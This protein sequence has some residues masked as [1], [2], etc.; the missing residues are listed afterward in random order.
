M[1]ECEKIRKK[2]RKKSEKNPGK[3]PKPVKLPEMVL[4]WVDTNLWESRAPDFWP[5]ECVQDIPDAEN[6]QR[7]I[8]LV[9]SLNF[10]FLFRRFEF[11]NQGQFLQIK[12]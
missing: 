5:R 9:Q 3:I 2:S 1:K 7:T 10:I 4:C 6:Q 11:D 8:P 12:H